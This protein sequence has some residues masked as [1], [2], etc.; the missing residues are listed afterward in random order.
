MHRAAARTGER[1]GMM[2]PET[3][4]N[5][6]YVDARFDGNQLM[7]RGERLTSEQFMTVSWYAVEPP[8]GSHTLGDGVAYIYN[9]GKL[10][11][12]DIPAVRL[13]AAG[14]RYYWRDTA[15]GDGLMFVLLLPQDHTLV[16]PDPLP[17][18]AKS[19]NGRIAVYWKPEGMFNAEVVMRWRLARLNESVD[20]AVERLNEQF[21]QTAGAP[22]NPGVHV[23]DP[24]EVQILLRDLLLAGFNDSDLD[25]LIFEMG[26]DHKELAAGDVRAKARELVR[27]M[28]HRS[29]L[30]EL[31]AAGKRHR[32]KLPWPIV[33]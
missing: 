9:A 23:A 5:L 10:T 16:D 25:D 11:V 26:F 27:Y 12:D 6:V 24:R 22:D 4:G 13:P 28:S 21:Q 33:E 19:H 1:S 29:R 2:S 7:G 30:P 20:R 31:I 15:K 32:P 17:R 14:G 8:A 18:E 3:P